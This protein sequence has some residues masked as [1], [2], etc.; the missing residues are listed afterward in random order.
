M[1]ITFKNGVS[2]YKVAAICDSTSDLLDFLCHQL[3]L[4]AERKGQILQGNRNV[5]F[6]LL[7]FHWLKF[8]LLL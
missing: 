6:S 1:E 8:C 5:M 3:I 7:C 2:L 4:A